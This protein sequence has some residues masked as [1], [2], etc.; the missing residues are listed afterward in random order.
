VS[1]FPLISQLK[2]LQRIVRAVK[3]KWLAGPL[4]K[5]TLTVAIL[6]LTLRCQIV[7]HNVQPKSELEKLPLATREGK[8]TFGCLVNGK[9][10]IPRS[11][12]DFFATDALVMYQAGVLQIWASAD[13]KGRHQ[14]MSFTI[15]NGV[16]AGVSYDLTNEPHERSSL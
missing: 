14:A 4:N 8:K 15:L 7:E 3:T 12:I 13:E 11:S 9:A 2:L 16:A 10:W 1:E 6:F 5:T